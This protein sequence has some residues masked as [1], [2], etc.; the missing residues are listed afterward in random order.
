M[1]SAGAAAAPTKGES[2]VIFPQLRTRG[3]ADG[4]VV[5]RFSAISFEQEQWSGARRSCAAAEGDGFI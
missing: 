4:S 3:L 1:S 2:G 5:P